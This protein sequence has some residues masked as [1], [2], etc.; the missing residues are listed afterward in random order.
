LYGLGRAELLH[1]ATVHQ[2]HLVGHFQRLLL[3]VRDEHAGHVQIVVQAAQPAAQFLAHL[4]VQRAERLVEQQHARLHG[5]RASQRDTLALA[6]RQLRGKRSASQSSC[7]SS[8][9]DFTFS[10]IFASDGR[11]PRGFTRRPKAVLEHGHVLEQRVVLEH[12]ADV[13]L[14]HVLGRGILPRQ[15]HLSRVGAFQARDD[16]QQRGLAA[17]RR[18]QQRR[19]FAFGEVQR[20]VVERDKSPKR[21]CT[22]LT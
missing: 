10:R 9:S 1:A 16:S 7:T 2:H 4:G 11:S 18:P 19:Q 3:V 20:D 8:S 15:H 6:A 22:F 12:E 21:L 17:A 14:A 5:Q 13:A